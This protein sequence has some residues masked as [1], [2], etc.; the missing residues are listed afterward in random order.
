[1]MGIDRTLNWLRIHTIPK[2]LRISRVA[3]SNFN[4][5][6]HPCRHNSLRILPYYCLL[7]SVQGRQAEQ[8]HGARQDVT[9]TQEQVH[10]SLS[11]ILLLILNFE[12]LPCRRDGVSELEHVGDDSGRLV[13]L[14]GVLDELRVTSEEVDDLPG[15]G[16]GDQ[17]GI[18]LGEVFGKDDVG[19]LSLD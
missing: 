2:T 14:H 7:H 18:D 5:H 10:S 13:V 16:L 15:L 12:E 6:V 17:A 4:R 1:M 3:V 19:V 11:E 9:G 8:P